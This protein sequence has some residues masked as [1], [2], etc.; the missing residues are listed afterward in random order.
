MRCEFQR[1]Y[2]A[3][4]RDDECGLCKALYSDLPAFSECL[5]HIQGYCKALQNPKI[6]VHHSIWRDLLMHIGKW[7]LQES[8]DESR[9]WTL[10]S[11]VR[12]VKHDEWEMRKI[13]KCI[14][15]MTDSRQGCS[16]VNKNI[17]GFHYE[18][19]C[20]DE[21]DFHDTDPDA[22]LK[23]RPDGVSFNAN[24]KICAFL[25][26]TRLMDSRDGAS[27]QPDWYTRADWS[28]DW[29]QDKDLERH[30]RYARHLEFLWCLS[31]RTGSN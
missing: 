14:G 9:K 11:S 10:P 16:I 5:E 2:L 31:K 29:A 21:N 26:L 18:R 8:E 24:E 13:L 27:D 12:A 6:A 20:W 7:S 15:V 3:R 1:L 25:K 22:F 19:R 30:T 28:L 4:L 23:I 17:S